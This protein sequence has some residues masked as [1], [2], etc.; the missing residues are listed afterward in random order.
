MRFVE[1]DCLGERTIRPG[2][3]GRLILG[4]GTRPPEDAFGAAQCVYIDPPFNTGAVFSFRQRVGAKGWT[5]GGR[6]VD[7]PAYD[8]R[9]ESREAYHAF[10]RDLIRGAHALLRD[11]G[12]F[13]LH[14]DQRESAYG[15]LLCD[16]VF[17]E[18]NLVNEIIW[19]YQSGGRSMKRFSAKHDTILFYRKSKRLYFDIRSVPIPRE[20][21]RNNHMKR[22]VDENG[23]S[24]RT[25]R[26]GG[27]VYTYYDDEPTYPTDVWSDVS[28]LQQKDPQRTGYDTQKPAALL[29]RIIAC[30]TKPGDL[31]ADLCCGSGTALIAA[32]EMDRRFLGMDLSE[33]ALSV[34][35]KRLA[36]HALRAEWPASSAGSKMEG[37]LFPG[38][39]F[40]DVCLQDYAPPPGADTGGISGLDLVDSWAVGFLR[41]GWFLTQ[42]MSLRTKLTPDL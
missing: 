38:I 21:N 35:R 22:K 34:T 31:V 1:I 36:D 29:K 20:G 26:T 14:L 24:F 16:E 15:R 3:D 28:H 19:C 7:L 42:D 2:A 30:A 32:A 41:D 11:T 8:D 39:G 13:F 12:A 33:S 40:T 6:T 9:F 25:I 37:D 18:E 10:L 5:D 23:R 4:D 27:K 17:G